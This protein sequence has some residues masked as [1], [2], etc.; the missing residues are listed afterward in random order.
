MVFYAA[1]NSI[2]VISRRQFTYS[3]LSRVSPVLGAF[4]IKAILENKT[5]KNLKN[6]WLTQTLIYCYVFI[7]YIIMAYNTQKGSF[8][9]LR[10][11]S[12]RISLRYPRRLIRDD[13]LRLY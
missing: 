13:T 1:F 12:S 10:K 5:K 7:Y 8:G 11:V 4:D 9:Y 6:D 3:C 2:S